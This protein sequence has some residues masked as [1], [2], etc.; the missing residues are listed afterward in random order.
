MSNVITD[1]AARLARLSDAAALGRLG[2]LADSGDLEPV[3]V[4]VTAMLASRFGESDPD[5]MLAAALAIRAPRHG[6]VCV[7]LRSVQPAAASNGTADEGESI[8][9]SVPKARDQWLAK[10]AASVLVRPPGDGNTPFVLR[11]DLLYTDRYFAYEAVLLEALRERFVQ[12]RP[13]ADQPLLQRGLGVLFGGSSERKRTAAAMALKRG[14]AVISGG[15]GTGK[16]WTVRNLL[17]LVFAQSMTDGVGAVPRVALAAPTGKAAA[18]V[19]TSIR[20][21]LDEHLQL[22]AGALPDG[23]EVDALRAFL[24]GA[25]PSTVHRLLGWRHDSATKF[26]H[27]RS[28]P[29]PFDLV[30]VDETSMVDLPVMAKLIDA[31]PPHARLVLLGDRH[32]LASVEAG[33]VLADICGSGEGGVGPHD[34]VVF[35]TESRRFG[36]DSGIG[37]FATTTVDGQVDQAMER[38]PL[39]GPNE[40]GPLELSGGEV[41]GPDLGR[42]PHKRGGGFPAAIERLVLAGYRSYLDRLRAGPRPGETLQ[43]LHAEVLR[44][45]DAFRVLCAHRAGR[46]GAEGMNQLV[47]ELLSAEGLITRSGSWWLGRPVMVTRNDYSVGRFNG[48][49]GI[50]VR[51]DEGAWAVAF[52][53]S[54]DGVTWLAPVRLP[55]HQTVF[56]MTIHKSQGSEF[57][58]LLVVLPDRPSPVLTREL[59]YTG[60]TRAKKRVTVLAD[61]AVLRH[62]LARRVQRASGLGEVLWAE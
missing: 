56:A 43:A 19:A 61:E 54:D 23:C 11:G 45:F 26:R 1:R 37:K 6:H 55:E 3:D 28:E 10:V 62:G 7:D 17:T 50:V 33:T 46:L 9:D 58:D 12:E 25:I 15:P 29:L 13:V 59:I 40:P 44:L 31:I 32:Q 21:G 14:L 53:G 48:D 49:I 8:A 52:P 36:A 34:A 60:V 51:D 2:P 27:D 38:L 20:Q 39:W 57:T 18:R 41:V 42:L 5:V 16:T 4:H 35:L 22:A 24:E 30:V 47:G